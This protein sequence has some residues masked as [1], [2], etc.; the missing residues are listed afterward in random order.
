MAEPSMA[1]VPPGFQV[2][3]GKLNIRLAQVEQDLD[4]MK[5]HWDDMARR[6]AEAEAELQ[7]RKGGRPKRTETA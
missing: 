5:G 3:V 7:R 4:R 1:N 6:L 2:Q